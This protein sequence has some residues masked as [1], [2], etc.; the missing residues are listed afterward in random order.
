MS[1][2]VTQFYQAFLHISTAS[3][4]CWGEKSL[5]RGQWAVSGMYQ[6][7]NVLLKGVVSEGWLHSTYEPE[8][9]FEVIHVAVYQHHKQKCDLSK[10]VS[11]AVSIAIVMSCP[12]RHPILGLSHPNLGTPPPNL[13][14][15]PS[16]LG[17]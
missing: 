1:L 11:T 9:E 14:T 3:D 6:N 13:G 8:S 5:V 4:K 12:V 7:G 2:H 17:A 16:H 15:P 10:L